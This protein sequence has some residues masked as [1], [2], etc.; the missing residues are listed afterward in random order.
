[1]PEYTKLSAEPR[2]VV[3]KQVRALRRA[4]IIPAVIYGQRDP[5]HVQLNT[6]S[7]TLILRDA[8]ENDVFDLEVEDKI[9]KVLLRDVQRH[10]TRRD[11]MHVDFL[12]VDMTLVIRTETPIHLVGKTELTDGEVGLLLHAVEIEAI[13]DKLV[14]HIEL[15]ISIFTDPDFIVHVRDLVL[16]EGLEIITDGDQPVAKFNASVV[17]ATDEDGEDT[18]E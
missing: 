18:A 9:Y 6:H 13:P 11:L 1:M 15:D 10:V 17:A 8:S 14:G 12:E 2:T 3:G 16:P 4:G 5:L 7:T